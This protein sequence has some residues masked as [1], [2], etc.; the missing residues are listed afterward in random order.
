MKKALAMA[1]KGALSCNFIAPKFRL[2]FCVKDFKKH[3]RFLPIKD[4]RD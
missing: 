1:K 4:F 3:T 2:N